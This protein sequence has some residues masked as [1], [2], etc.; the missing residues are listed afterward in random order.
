MKR[1]TRYVTILLL[2]LAGVSANAQEGE[3]INVDRTVG[4]G[5]AGQTETVDFTA[6]KTYLGVEAVDYDMLRIVNP[7]GSTIS[8][9]APFDGWFTREG[10]AETWGANTFTCVK[11]FEAIPDGQYTICDMNNPAEGD[12][13]T[14]KWAL[15]ANAKTYTYTINVKY[16]AAAAVEMTVTDLGISTSVE[17]DVSEASYTEKTASITDEQVAAI[18][19]RLGL[20]SL[21]EAKVF[22][23]NPTTQ[24]LV[25]SYAGYDGW[26]N[27]DGDFANWAGNSTVPV[28]VKY[29][30]GKTFYCYNIAGCE[31]QT[32]KTYWAVANE[33]EAVLIEI[34]FVYT[35]TEPETPALT[36]LDKV[37]VGSVSY[38][39]SEPSYTEKIVT[40]SSEDV[41]TICSSLGLTY[42]GQAKV[43]GY[44][45]TTKELISNYV[46]YDGWRNTDGD[47]ASWAGNNT[48]PACV[49]Y[50][51]GQKFYCYNIA[52]CEPQT[53]KTY[54]AMANDTKA[55]LIEIDF[56]YVDSQALAVSAPVSVQP[57]SANVYDLQGRRVA[58][59]QL[60]K[61]LYIVGGRLIMK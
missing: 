6:A 28:C 34:D 10:I 45:P 60:K 14:V 35:S 37:I 59:G 4:L 51:D 11:F 31:P 40:L 25:G 30:D 32:I 61:G 7:D 2:T 9:Y 48:V 12:V 29:D 42:P 50:G 47:F 1:I 19:T 55:M 49:K 17:F 24:E 16:V 57:Q 23:Y 41:S 52:G 58:N 38:D 15:E 53:I 54:W 20:Q 5:Y 27:A 44:N 56:T 18:C 22:G 39:V 8:D 43:Y 26:R 33:T 46:G 3:V 13:C 36:I 21:S